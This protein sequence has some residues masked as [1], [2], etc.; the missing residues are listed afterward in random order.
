ME[1]VGFIKIGKGAH[2]N[3]LHKKGTIFCNNVKYFR[4]L[5]DTEA[6]FRGDKFDGS[7]QNIIITSLELFKNNGETIPFSFQKGRLNIYDNRILSNHLFCLYT[8]KSEVIENGLFFDKRNIGLGDQA[9]IITDTNEFKKR[10]DV[11]MKNLGVKY[12]FDF[13]NYYD[14]EIDQ[15]ELSVF[16]K[17]NIFYFQRELRFYFL[18]Q[19]N[20]T[21]VFNIGS[22]EDISV[23][24]DTQDLLSLHVKI[25]TEKNVP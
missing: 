3:E 2:I 10:I 20:K 11:K 13:V 5:E 16:D 1:V 9:L 14:S 17:R 22:I 15:T 4:E 23:V 8:I 25:D 19:P 18:G 21:F 24:V 7:S 12:A 6:Q